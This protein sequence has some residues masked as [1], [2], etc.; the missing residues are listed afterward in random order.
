M[1]NG[2]RTH[3]AGL[4]FSLSLSF[5]FLSLSLSILNGRV[6]IHE[7]QF[8]PG[9]NQN[10]STQ[11]RRTHRQHTGW[12]WQTGWL[13]RAKVE[14]LCRRLTTT[15]FS[16]LHTFRQH[17]TRPYLACVVCPSR[18]HQERDKK[19]CW[20]KWKNRHVIQRHDT[21][22]V[23]SFS[24]GFRVDFSRCGFLV[25]ECLSTR[26]GGRLF[27][28]ENSRSDWRSSNRLNELPGWNHVAVS[29]I[30]G[31]TD[32]RRQRAVAVRFWH[33]S[34]RSIMLMHIVSHYETRL[35]YTLVY[36]ERLKFHSNSMQ[37]LLNKNGRTILS[38]L[39]LNQQM[40]IY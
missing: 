14:L 35:M 26:E 27:C 34:Y 13:P 12:W 36:L 31:N 29:A 25:F 22:H 28:F 33:F 15:T 7:L 39:L 10:I 1:S 11:Q 4:T 18:W 5:F 16:T 30:D 6:T 40:I 21:T 9:Q 20:M 37:Q 17:V 3:R 8:S 2:P 32:T 19:N 38:L 23:D 24:S